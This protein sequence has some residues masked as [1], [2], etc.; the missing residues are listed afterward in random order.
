MEAEMTNGK[1][2]LV[3]GATGGVGGETARTLIAH[4]WTVRGLARTPRAGD[5]IDWIVGDA[6][7]AAAVLRAAQGASAIV[8]A[9]NPP[10]YRDWA[11]LA[12]PMLANSIAAA[13]SVG[14]RL[15]LPGTIYNYDPRTTPLASE[16]SPQRPATRKGAIRVAMEQAIEAACGRGMRAVVLRAGDYFG[17]RPGNSWL[18]QGLVTPG[19]PVRRVLY[20]GTRGAGHGWA[21]LPD[22]AETFARLLDRDADLPAFARYHFRGIWDGDGTV[23]IAAIRTATGNPRIKTVGFP[24]FALPLIAPFNPTMREMIEMRPYWQYPVALDNRALVAVLGEEPH[25]PLDV[26]MRATLSALGC[27]PAGGV[28]KGAEIAY[29]PHHA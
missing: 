29:V 19:K 17:P 25:T 14:A 12:L 10:G 4:G 18:S 27:L 1:T 2:A 23:L 11:K 15:A 26:A 9:V 13:E 8:H 5:G 24:W 6:L 22:I 16:A 3:L 28:E 7:D 21:Y 20:P